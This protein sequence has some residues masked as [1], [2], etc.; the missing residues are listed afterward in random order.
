MCEFRKGY[1]KG[2]RFNWLLQRA[3]D[4]Y[5][6]FPR[7]CQVFLGPEFWPVQPLLNSGWPL[8]P[9]FSAKW[10]IDAFRPVKKSISVGRKDFLLLP[11]V[12]S[13]LPRISL[14][15]PEV[16]SPL[17]G[18]SSRLPQVSSPLPEVS[19]VLFQVSSALP[20]VSFRPF[21]ILKSYGDFSMSYGLISMSCR[22]ISRWY[23]LVSRARGND[24][25]TPGG[26]KGSYKACVICSPERGGIKES[27]WAEL[28]R[29]PF[30]YESS[31]LPN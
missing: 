20:E 30:D 24:S 2:S 14:P 31:A 16:S 19:S 13:L 8:F 11:E 26:E 4:L 17:P 12:S 6:V 22:R 25:K 1:R 27:R 3:E 28:N 5:N 23:G 21:L 15:F 10:F 18:V 7:L 9:P 29:R